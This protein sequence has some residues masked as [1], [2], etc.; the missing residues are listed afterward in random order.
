VRRKSLLLVAGAVAL[1]AA[2][3]WFHFPPSLEASPPAACSLDPCPRAASVDLLPEQVGLRP[4]GLPFAEPAGP[5]SWLVGQ[6]YGN[7]RQA[8]LRRDEI[9]R[10]GQGLHFGVDLLAACGTPVVAIG[11]G[12]V[13]EVDR[14]R[15]APPH[16]LLIS[17]ANG[18]VSF[19]GHLL[20]K[21]ALAVGQGV[22]A[23]Q[24]VALSGDFYLTCHSAPHLHLEMRSADLLTAYNPV[25]LIEADWDGLL[26]YGGGAP[27]FQRDLADPRRW[28][29]IGDQPDVRFGG[30]LL[31]D[32][33]A[34][35]PPDYRPTPTPTPA[36]Q[37]GES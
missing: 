15:S 1:L 8:F 9:Y 34:P 10:N 6:L 12:V 29:A 28:Q 16:N 24:V 25:T 14:P 2:L 21:P 30:R 33:V 26:L 35:W 3:S 17:H 4:F 18:Y 5:D 19:Y 22:T 13:L 20:E 31:N 23:G 32:Y 7:T 11:D 37:A 27:T 36:V